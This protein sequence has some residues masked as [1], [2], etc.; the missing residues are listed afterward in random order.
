M[1]TEVDRGA[2]GGDLTLPSG[3]H[4]APVLVDQ[5]QPQPGG[6]PA[7]RPR[8]CLRIVGEAR[9]GVKAGLQHAVQLDEVAAHPLPELADGLDRAR[10]AAGDDDAER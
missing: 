5:P 1:V 3:R 6:G 4:I 10:G 2:V 8:D 7:H 9:V